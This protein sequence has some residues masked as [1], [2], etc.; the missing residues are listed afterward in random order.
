MT[1]IIRYVTENEAYQDD[2]HGHLNELERWS[3]EIAERLA[4]GEGLALTAEHWD[5]LFFLRSYF[6]LNGPVSTAREQSQILERQFRI[7][8]GKRYL[9]QLFPGGPVRQA[10]HIAGLP[11]PAGSADLSFGTVE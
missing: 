10:S 7:E 9:F 4:L 11:L 5:V 2:P 6:K 1:D 8:G 3:E